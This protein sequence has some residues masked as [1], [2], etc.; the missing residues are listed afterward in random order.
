MGSTTSY[1]GDFLLVSIEP[2]GCRRDRSMLVHRDQDLA[3][4]HETPTNR[5]LGHLDTYVGSLTY[6]LWL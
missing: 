4:R 1:D 3:E 2:H 5:D 6:M